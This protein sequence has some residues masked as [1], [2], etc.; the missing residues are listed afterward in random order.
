MV[1]C[2]LSSR[3]QPLWS[4]LIKQMFSG[5]VIAPIVIIGLG[6]PSLYANWEL[7]F[8]PG[9]GLFNTS[10]EFKVR[11]LCVSN[12][13]LCVSIPLHLGELQSIH[14]SG[15]LWQQ[16]SKHLC[17]LEAEEG[18]I[19]FVSLLICILAFFLVLFCRV[20]ETNEGICEICLGQC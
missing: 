3:S 13:Q 2:T 15:M 8:V 19:D 16:C 17:L 7:C 5:K 10:P 6:K 12:P 11:K 18:R 20:V 4:I 1:H 14:L 9:K